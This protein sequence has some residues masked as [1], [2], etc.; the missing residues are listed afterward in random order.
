VAKPKLKAKQMEQALSAAEA[1]LAE[2]ASE[3]V[4][5]RVTL[6]TERTQRAAERMEIYAQ[7]EK[8]QCRTD[9]LEWALVLAQEVCRQREL[10]LRQKGDK[11]VLAS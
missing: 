1:D 8:A 7:V 2:K 11:L 3:L 10:E 5:L 4:N 9:A 6:Q